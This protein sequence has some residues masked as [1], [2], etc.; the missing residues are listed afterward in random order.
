M[1]KNLSRPPAL[2]RI[3]S[4]AIASSLFSSL[5]QQAEAFAPAALSTVTPSVSRSSFSSWSISST[6]RDNIDHLFDSYSNSNSNAPPASVL[7][8]VSTITVPL[9][10]LANQYDHSGPRG[11]RDIILHL[12]EQMQSFAERIAILKS[13]SQHLQEGDDYL[14]EDD[15]ITDMKNQLW[16]T[17]SSLKCGR[18]VDFLVGSQVQGLKG[19]ILS[20]MALEREMED[21][22]AF[23]SELREQQDDSIS[24]EGRFNYGAWLGF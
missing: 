9:Q 2:L 23:L 12:D 7:A 20:V 4:L 19:E 14:L 1:S 22:D 13:V 3:L 15:E 18:H 17:A 8:D 6:T 16:T 11:K 21:K 10:Q 24:S 5:N